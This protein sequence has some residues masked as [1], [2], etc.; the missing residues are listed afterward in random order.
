VKTGGPPEEVLAAFVRGARYKSR[1][2][3]NAYELIICTEMVCGVV[4]RASG[5]KCEKYERKK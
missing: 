2:N 3:R 4:K 1:V 5:Y